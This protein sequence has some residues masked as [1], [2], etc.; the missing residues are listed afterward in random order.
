MGMEEMQKYVR[1][2]SVDIYLI[3]ILMLASRVLLTVKY[4]N[5]H[6]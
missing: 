6:L 4:V 2:V 5:Y 3:C 1:N